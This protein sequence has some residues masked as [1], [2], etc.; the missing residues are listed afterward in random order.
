MKK[1]L[2]SIVLLIF[3]LTGCTT[4]SQTEET[5]KIA[6]ILNDVSAPWTASL[7]E[8]M[9]TAASKS[10]VELC[11]I[12]GEGSASVQ[13]SATKELIENGYKVIILMA[14]DSAECDEIVR[15]CKD[16]EVK[17]VEVNCLTDSQGYDAFVG[18]DDVSAGSLQAEYLMSTLPQNVKVCYLM[19]PA[20]QSG[21]IKRLEGIT[22]DLFD[23][24]TDIT[25]LEQDNADWNRD[26]AKNITLDWLDKHPDIDAFICQ[27]DEMA[28]GV[29][30]AID[31]KGLQ[32]KIIVT[33]VDGMPEA[34]EAIKNGLMDFT[35]F[36]NAEKQ[37]EAAINA[38][39]R[40]LNSEEVPKTEI[41]SFEPITKENADDY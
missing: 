24:R 38:A 34:I 33:G 39:I 40:L 11:V 32:E 30:D 7:G 1:T 15:L 29:I 10:G 14:A 19:G 41:I 21:Q 35:T 18:S 20:G 31:S 17:L 9:Q 25:I 12:D 37:A 22:K 8:H 3:I 2:L 16:A 5:N 28:L 27:N 23:I 13:I 4:P 26:K 6:A 36:Q